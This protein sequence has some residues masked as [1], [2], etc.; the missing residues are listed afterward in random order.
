[1]FTRVFGGDRD[2]SR[3]PLQVWEQF[4][5][6]RQT[7]AIDPQGRPVPEPQNAEDPPRRPVRARTVESDAEWLWKVLGWA[8]EADDPEGRPL[9]RVHPLKR[10]RF[11]A[12]IPR[13]VNPRRPVA[14]QDRY[15]ALLAV[16]DQVHPYLGPLLA[17]VNGT[18][19]RIGAVTQ[20]RYADLQ[21]A[22]RKSAPHGAIA[23]PGETDKMGKAWSAPLNAAVR[24]TLDALLAARPGLGAAYLFPAPK[25]A[26]KP[27]DRWLASKWLEEAQLLAKLPRLGRSLWH[28]YRPK[29]ATERKHLPVQDVAMAGG[30]TNAATLQ[31]IYQQP[32]EGMLYRVVSEPAELREVKA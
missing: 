21:L 14:T 7:G 22:K 27:V 30:W 5:R 18:G 19:R 11:R 23:W 24:A 6:Q 20:L 25:N 28:A 10:E 8:T 2:L 3:L 9:L 29:L 17:L 13:V 4:L 15:E 1:M 31:L 12:A 26:G 16:A 32:D